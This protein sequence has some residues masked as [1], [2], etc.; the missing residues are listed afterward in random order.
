[1]PSLPVQTDQMGNATG[2]PT[3][4]PSSPPDNQLP[5]N[6]AIQQFVDSFSKAGNRLLGLNG[7]ERYQL[8][9]ERVLREG[10]SAPHDVMNTKV[11]MTSEDMIP[12]AMSVAALAGSGGIAGA[13]EDAGAATLGSTPFLRPALKYE[14]KL[15]KGPV[16]GEHYDA[17]PK[18]L[19]STF[20]KQAMSG[21]DLSNFNFGFT[22]H[23]GHFLSRE[24]AL[25]Y[26]I[27][28]GLIHPNSEAARVGTLAS[29]MQLSADSSKP[30][31]AI[32]ALKPATPFYSAAEKAIGDIPQAKMTGEQWLGTL[33]NKP[34][35]KSEEL[36]W[37]GLKS[38][39]SDKGKETVSKADI[40]S[41]VQDNA[42]KI[43]EKTNIDKVNIEPTVKYLHE[44]MGPATKHLQTSQDIADARRFNSAFR[45]TT[46]GMSDE[47]VLAAAR[48][49]E[50]YEGMGD[51][52]YHSYQLPGGENYQEKLLTLPFDRRQVGMNTEG[53]L[54][55]IPFTQRYIGGQKA[56]DVY[57]SSHW[58]EPNVLA[59]IRTNDRDVGGVASKH[60]EEIQSD[61]HQQGRDQGYKSD[62]K[63]TPEETAKSE[64]NRM[65]GDGSWNRAPEDTRA[66]WIQ[67]AGRV[68]G[69]SKGVPDAPFKK[70]WP[71]LAMKRTIRQAIDEGKS[72]VSWTPGEA[73]A[74]RYDLSKQIDQ[75]KYI[76]NDDG[77]YNVVPFKNNSPV[78]SIEKE[79]VKPE[80]LNN[81]VGKEVAKKI[82]G[83][84]GKKEGHIGVLEGLDLKVGGEGM[85][86]FYD[87]MLPAMVEKIGKK[88]GV[89][90]KQ[91]EATKAQT[92]VDQFGKT[93]YEPAPVHYFDIP[94]KMKQDILT[95]G[96]PLFSK[97]VPVIPT[98]RDK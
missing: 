68:G 14:G 62:Y 57:K 1:M 36:D 17:I 19:H 8:W 45:E 15:Y 29:T 59:H 21:E 94:D 52:K 11:P 33:A 66:N 54:A 82:T 84:E 13:G 41:F 50:T 7:E 97:G 63:L 27:D 44:S 47:D 48:K 96:F 49:S 24:D 83:G 74:A 32:E 3:D 46:K 67:D 30:G 55:G 6:S 76:K 79:N 86:S 35:V 38:F 89:K 42:L 78:H 61:W 10:I 56:S 92:Y 81:I 64:Y 37:T 58:D 40:Q 39:L 90:V 5:N 22:N 9:P 23:K 34:G 72:R 31:A 70:S 16:G 77:T 2:L 73:Q 91:G 98:Q 71:E 95:K 53:D 93:K 4:Q 18:E 25:K 20:Q 28:E 75:L 26:A 88:Y 12:A 69:I 65:Y 87:Q 80:E 51:S 85:K 43:G 60:I